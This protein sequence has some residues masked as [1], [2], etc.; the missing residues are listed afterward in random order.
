[1]CVC[2]LVFPQYGMV[3][4]PNAYTQSYMTQ[5]AVH[6]QCTFHRQAMDISP[7]IRFCRSEPFDLC[8]PLPNSAGDF[9]FTQPTPTVVRF[10]YSLVVRQSSVFHGLELGVHDIQQWSECYYNSHTP[11]DSFMSR[12]LYMLYSYNVTAIRFLS[13]FRFFWL[14]GI[15]LLQCLPCVHVVN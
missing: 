12:M 11:F 9:C 7:K 13:A 4:L 14:H 15:L 10:A 8:Y 6:I 2:V 1:M 5:T 3:G